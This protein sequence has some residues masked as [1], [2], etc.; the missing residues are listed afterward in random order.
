MTFQ[1]IAVDLATED[2]YHYQP[3]HPHLRH[4]QFIRYQSPDANSMRDLY[5][6]HFLLPSG[7]RIEISRITN[8]INSDIRYSVMRIET[9]G[10][11]DWYMLMDRIATVVQ[12]LHSIRD[13]EE[14]GVVSSQVSN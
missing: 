8:P 13:A 4:I 12:L 5:L 14:P 1:G 2:N 9:D 7:L 6:A 10:T 11:K 3:I